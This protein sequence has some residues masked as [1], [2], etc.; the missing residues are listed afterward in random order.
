[1]TEGLSSGI[2]MASKLQNLK[3]PSNIGTIVF[4]PVELKLSDN[5]DQS[6]MNPYC[7][8]KLG[9]RSGKCQFKDQEIHNNEILEA[10]AIRRKINGNL[11]KIKVKDRNKFILNDRIGEASLNTD[12]LVIQGRMSVWLKLMKGGKEVGEI[13]MEM[14]FIPAK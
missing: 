13:F 8:V 3:R 1:M 4:M 14:S 2:P 7:K 5:Q 12:D 9:S 6:K 11:A 10:V